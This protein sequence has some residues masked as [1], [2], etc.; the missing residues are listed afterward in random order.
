MGEVAHAKSDYV[1]MTN[2]S[3]RLEDPA[4]IV[5]VNRRTLI[6]RLRGERWQWLGTETDTLGVRVGLERITSG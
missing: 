4:K 1:I 5:Q 3:P 6:L 2:D